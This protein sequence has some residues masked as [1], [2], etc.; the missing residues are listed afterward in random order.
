MAQV[1]IFTEP[2][3]LANIDFKRLFKRFQRGNLQ[4][5]LSNFAFPYSGDDLRAICGAIEWEQINLTDGLSLTGD[6]QA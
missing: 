6:S 3:I 1:E 4:K 5:L 2:R